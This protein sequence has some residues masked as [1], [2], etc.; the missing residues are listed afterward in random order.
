MLNCPSLCLY[1]R[2]PAWGGHD[3]V[4]AEM[5]SAVLVNLW[6]ARCDRHSEWYSDI[7]PKNI[8]YVAPGL[9]N[10][11]TTIRHCLLLYLLT[12]TYGTFKSQGWGKRLTKIPLSYATFTI[13][14]TPTSCVDWTFI[15]G[16]EQRYFG[17]ISTVDH[18]DLSGESDS[19]SVFGFECNNTRL[20]WR[21]NS[22][23]THGGI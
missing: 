1:R 22:S 20:G 7:P 13:L 8:L 16:I 17:L 6:R 2:G 4:T 10:L 23:H 14:N 11:E 3:W 18:L 19:A 12:E 5:D 9:Q 15:S 21:T